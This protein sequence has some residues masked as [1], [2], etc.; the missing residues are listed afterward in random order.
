MSDRWNTI[1]LIA[2]APLIAGL[3][4]AVFSG[5]L[6]STSSLEDWPRSSLDMATTMFVMALA[7]IWFGCSGTAREIVNE[8]P[9]YRRERMVGLSVLSYLSSI[10]PH[11]CVHCFV[12]RGGHFLCRRS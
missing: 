3:I 5:V 1:V 12:R 4:A 8:W 6:R 7:A 10:V 11:L 9:V 2:Q